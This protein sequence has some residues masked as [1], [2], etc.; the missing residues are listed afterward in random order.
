MLDSA[1]KLLKAEFLLEALYA[2]LFCRILGFIFKFI[3]IF[4]QVYL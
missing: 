1:F 4:F 3:E 2:S